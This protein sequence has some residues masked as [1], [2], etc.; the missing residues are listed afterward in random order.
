MH[1]WKRNLVV[2]TQRISINM[3]YILIF[4]PIFCFGQGGDST[5]YS[6]RWISCDQHIGVRDLPKR[7]K[8]ERTIT[9]ILVWNGCVVTE[10][11]VYKITH[12][13]EITVAKDV[14]NLAVYIPETIKVDIV[15]EYF[16]DGGWIKNSHVIKEL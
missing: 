11:E 1:R 4:L 12:Y 15:T 6:V 10:I 14:G 16:Y 5:L 2:I 13:N 9:K 3:K 7:D 8:I